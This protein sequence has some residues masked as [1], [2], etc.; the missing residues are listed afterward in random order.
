MDTLVAHKPTEE[1]DAIVTFADKMKDNLQIVAYAGCGKTSTIELVD[2][3]L[4]KEPRLYLAFNKRVVTEIVEKERVNY[5]TLCKTLNSL[6]HGVWAKAITARIVVDTKGQKTLNAFKSI[7]DALPKGMVDTKKDLWGMWDEIKTAVGFAKAFGYIPDGATNWERRLINREDFFSGL[8]DKLEL[9]GTSVVD[10][11]LKI[12]IKQAYE[13]YIDFNDQLYMPSLFGGTFPK[14]PVV[15]V[16]E[17]QDLSAINHKMMEKLCR[18]SRLFAVGDPYQSIYQFR[19][20]AQDGMYKLRHKHAMLV[21]PLSISFRCPQAIVENA[22]WRAPGFA[23]VKAGG[24]VEVLHSLDLS[25]VPDGSAFIC[26]NNAPLFRLALNLLS[27][28]RSVSMA[29][30]D[31]GPR[32]LNILKKL[33]D[34]SLH[35]A[36]VLGAIDEWQDARPYSKS[37]PD[38]ADCLRVFVSASKTLG[39]AIAYA[40]FVLAQDGTIHLSTGHKAKGLEWPVVYHLDPWILSQTEQDL[41]LRYVIQTRSAGEYYEINSDQIEA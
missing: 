29:G 39:E 15:M 40:N 12:S 34:E 16:D 6:G 24:K 8:E 13:G 37:A 25:R 28:E 9:I 22:R 10:E 4:P 33:G 32:L 18:H 11:I 1:Q 27:A 3:V 20:A 41:N 5:T 26:R 31:I 36:G 21:R 7:L 30:T 23:W 17:S 38:I 2:R 14:F 35:R 19:G